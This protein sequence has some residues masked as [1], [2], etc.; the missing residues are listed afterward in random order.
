MSGHYKFDARDEKVDE[1][2]LVTNDIYE[3][4]SN[5]EHSTSTCDTSKLPVTIIIIFANCNAGTADCLNLV[6]LHIL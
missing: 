2:Q 5:K 1:V 6:W 4:L 3:E